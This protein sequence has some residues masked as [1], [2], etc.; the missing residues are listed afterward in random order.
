MP[1]KTS[2]RGVYRAAFVGPGWLRTSA[3]PA[4]A[5]SGLGGW[6]GKEFSTDGTAVN[7]VLR[8]G[9]FSTRFPM[10]LVTAKS[11]IDGRDGLAIYYQTGNPFPWMHIVDELRQMDDGTLLGM[12]LANING[13]RNLAFPFTLQ[14]QEHGYGL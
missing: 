8:A 12:T 5:L 11:F 9:K 7:I 1:D 10:K 4:L 14:F 3:G 6:W 2:I 13:L